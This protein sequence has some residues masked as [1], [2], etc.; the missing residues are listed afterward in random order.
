[1][2]GSCCNGE[3]CFIEILQGLRLVVIQASGLSVSL[4]EEDYDLME[5]KAFIFYPFIY[6]GIKK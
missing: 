4:A 6:K 1:L 5:A 3:I 2:S